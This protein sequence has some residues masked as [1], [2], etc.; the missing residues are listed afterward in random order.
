MSARVPGRWTL[1][2]HLLFILHHSAMLQ[3]NSPFLVSSLLFCIPFMYLL[4]SVPFF[5]VAFIFVVYSSYTTKN[6]TSYFP[7]V[8]GCSSLAQIPFRI[9][10]PYSYSSLDSR[11]VAIVRAF[12][13]RLT[14]HCAI[15]R[16]VLKTSRNPI[17]ASR[18][19]THQR[20]PCFV[21][22]RHGQRSVSA[23]WSVTKED[24]KTVEGHSP[25]C[26]NSTFKLDLSW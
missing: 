8:S 16:Y 23:S 13:S 4:L 21:C 20:A 3:F 11:S 19:I 26:E 6:K 12:R 14:L 25:T 15:V 9:H 22:F 10:S 2:L 24:D 18:R 17:A 7:L 1:F 5:L